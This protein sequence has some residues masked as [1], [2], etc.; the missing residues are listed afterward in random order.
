MLWVNNIIHAMKSY[1][2]H[3]IINNFS[4]K[5]DSVARHTLKSNA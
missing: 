3:N 4:V 2:R 1:L 5:F